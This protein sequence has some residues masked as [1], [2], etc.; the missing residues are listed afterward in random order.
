VIISGKLEKGDRAGS[1]RRRSARRY[2]IS[3][4]VDQFDERTFYRTERGS[5]GCDSQFEK[6]MDYERYP[7]FLDE[8]I[9]L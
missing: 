8:R 3:R 9:Y 5:A 2:E 6:G 4:V 1:L 7:A